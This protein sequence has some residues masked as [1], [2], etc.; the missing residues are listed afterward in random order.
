MTDPLNIIVDYFGIWLLGYRIEF[1][2]LY[3]LQGHYFKN[4]LWLWSIYEYFIL[5]ILNESPALIAEL[6]NDPN[7]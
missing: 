7:P 4:T 2:C 6:Y 3:I 1:K 5:F